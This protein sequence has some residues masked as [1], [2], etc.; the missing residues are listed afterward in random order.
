M[1]EEMMCLL[2]PPHLRC[3]VRCALGALIFLGLSRGGGGRSSSALT[4][5]G[6]AQF[7]SL[8]VDIRASALSCA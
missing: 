2:D 6:L 4:G 7:S 5:L 8:W 1:V 3:Y